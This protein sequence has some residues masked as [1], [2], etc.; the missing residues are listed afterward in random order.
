MQNR[1]WLVKLQSRLLML[2]LEYGDT[3]HYRCWKQTTSEIQQL[4]QHLWKQIN[5]L[6]P[7]IKIGIEERYPVEKDEGEG[8]IKSCQVGLGTE[9][10]TGRW[11]RGV[12][13]GVVE[14]WCCPDP[15]NNKEELGNHIVQGINIREMLGRNCRHRFILKIK[16]CSV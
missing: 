12:V 2:N 6:E 4:G 11:V 3:R 10:L 13:G 9:W 14:I 7:F 1:G 15:R 8:W 16:K 5:R